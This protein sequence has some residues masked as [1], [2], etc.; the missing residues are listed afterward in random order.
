MAILPP[1]NVE[2]P[3]ADLIRAGFKGSKWAKNLLPR[4]LLPVPAEPRLGLKDVN[5]TSP[6]STTS[7]NIE[8]L[9]SPISPASRGLQSPSDI[10]PLSDTGRKLNSKSSQSGLRDGDDDKYGKR[11]AGFGSRIWKDESTA[12][13][14][15]KIDPQALNVIQDTFLDKTTLDEVAEELPEATPRY[16]LLST[17]VVHNDGRVQV[18]IIGIYY[19]PLSSSDK[20]RMLYASA[21]SQVFQAADIVK[22]YDLQESE[23]LNDDWLRS[24]KIK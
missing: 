14:I 18:P 4:K 1:D 2:T 3:I 17:K 9:T 7:H 19:H 23:E 16:I 15:L 6:A 22:V 11:A 20:N 10:T 21:K 13:L 8:R 24:L 12:A 5:S